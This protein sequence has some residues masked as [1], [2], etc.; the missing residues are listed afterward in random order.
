MPV[1]HLE[2]AGNVQG[3]GFRWFIRQRA[4]EL[5]LAGWVRNL[6][7]GNVEF[8]ASGS[9]E[10][11][12]MLVA[13]VRQGPEGAEVKLLINLTPQPSLELPLPFTILK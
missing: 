13:S 3:V 8:A 6:S 2:V 5:H 10:G 12:L 1:V 7:S 11:I 9:A 4:R